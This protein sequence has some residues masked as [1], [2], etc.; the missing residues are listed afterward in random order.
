MVERILPLFPL[1]VVLFP[2]ALLPI[3]V[4]EERYR[5]L[6]SACLAG[7]Q[8]FGVVLIRSGPEVGGPAVPYRVGTV[9]RIVHVERLA[10]GRF[11]L[12][13]VGVTR[14]RLLEEVPGQPYPAGRVEVLAPEG[15]GAAPPDLVE[16]LRSEFRAYLGTLGAS[17]PAGAALDPDELAFAAAARLRIPLLEQQALLEIDD[18]AMRLRRVLQVL[19]R[20]HQVLRLLTRAAGPSMIGPFSPN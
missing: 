9:A 18:T 15:G 16:E 5:A 13:V 12:V 17:L 6:V 3:H 7:D 19:R 1:N 4:F 11:N 10:D 14:F 20:E 8:Q 2:G